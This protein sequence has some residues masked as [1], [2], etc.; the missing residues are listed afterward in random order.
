ML[1]L[2]D[3]RPRPT[4]FPH[5]HKILKLFAL[6][7]K[8]YRSPPLGQ[9][10]ALTQTPSLRGSSSAGSSHQLESLGGLQPGSGAHKLALW[11]RFWLPISGRIRSAQAAHCGLRPRPFRPVITEAARGRGGPSGDLQPSLCLLRH[12][13]GPP[14]PIKTS[15]S[16]LQ[17][18]RRGEA[19]QRR[20]GGRRGSE[21]GGG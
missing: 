11:R 18:Q 9:I 2:T 1:F 14:P 6:L 4:R 7:C 13:L 15:G 12:P 5:F 10:R 8:P 16:G 20:G 21:M 3:L 17:S 19:S